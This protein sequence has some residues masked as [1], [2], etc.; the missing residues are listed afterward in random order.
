MEI[1]ISG[2]SQT[3]FKTVGEREREREREREIG[4]VSF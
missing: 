2:P 1:A 4:R 3:G